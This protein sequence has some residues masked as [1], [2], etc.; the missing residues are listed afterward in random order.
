LSGV[1]AERGVV[2]HLDAEVT[3]VAAGSLQT[4]SGEVLA[5]DEIVWVTQAGGAPWLRETG[6]ALDE[7]GFHPGSR[8]LAN[9][10]RSADLC[11]RRL[12]RDGRSPAGK[13]RGLRRAHGQAAG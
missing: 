10:N 7:K 5:A 3:Q 9:R 8:H 11:R 6:L 2:V 1:L 4:A 12:R 13:G